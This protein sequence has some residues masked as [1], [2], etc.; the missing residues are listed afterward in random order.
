MMKEIV[1]GGKRMVVRYAGTRE[2]SVGCIKP[3]FMGMKGYVLCGFLGKKQSL[4]S[5][6]RDYS[7]HMKEYR[8]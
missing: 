3:C 2:T 6:A 5:F 8:L 7:E 4:E 1:I